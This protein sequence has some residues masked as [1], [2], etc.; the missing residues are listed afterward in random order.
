MDDVIA[1]Q[2]YGHHGEMALPEISLA[3][4]PEGMKF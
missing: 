2:R 1:F 4:I 3:P